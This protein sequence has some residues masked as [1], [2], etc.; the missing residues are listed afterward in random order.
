M[1]TLLLVLTMI[2]P[3]ATCRGADPCRVCKNCRYCKYCSVRG[4]HCGVC[5]KHPEL[6]PKQRRSHA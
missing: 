5:K 2:A 6:H 4:H 3:L 1:H